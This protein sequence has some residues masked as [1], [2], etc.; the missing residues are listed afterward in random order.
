MV[1]TNPT[2]Y[3]FDFTSPF[4]VC[5]L[6]RLLQSITT[7]WTERWH[8][9]FPCAFEIESAPRQ[10]LDCRLSDQQA[11]IAGFIPIVCFS[12]FMPILVI[13]TQLTLQRPMI[14]KVAI[15]CGGGL[16]FAATWLI[17]CVMMF[18][19]LVLAVILMVYY[20]FDVVIRYVQHGSS[21]R[22]MT[23]YLIDKF[24]DKHTTSTRQFATAPC[25]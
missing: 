1:T 14:A 8:S 18:C 10:C 7:R 4:V 22:T 5:E 3:T 2:N 16:A 13:C 6:F 20:C 9:F 19:R 11:A 23:Q 21:E 17:F 25:A 15:L 24:H 12:A